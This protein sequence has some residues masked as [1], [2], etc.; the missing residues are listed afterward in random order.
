[1][2]PVYR[3]FRLLFTVL[4]ALPMTGPSNNKAA[5]TTIA[6][7]TRINAYSTKPWPLSRGENNMAFS[8]FF[9]ISQAGMR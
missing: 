7:K 1:M 2:G 8:P 4:N 6:T 3:L 5:I 9:K